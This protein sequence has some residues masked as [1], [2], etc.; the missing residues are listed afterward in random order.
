MNRRGYTILEMMAVVAIIGILSAIAGMKY[1]SLLRKANEGGVIG[2]LGSLRSAI[3]IYYADMEGQYPGAL[4][5][6]TQNPKLISSLAAIAPP[7]FHQSSA[8]IHNGSVANDTGGWMYDDT[9]GTTF[10]TVWV[11]CTHTDSKGTAWNAY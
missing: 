7:P 5:S 8:V 1:A 9:G 4:A 11:N 3:S 6:L 2:Q 10:G